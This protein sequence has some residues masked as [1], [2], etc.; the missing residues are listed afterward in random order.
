MVLFA[1]R[2]APPSIEENLGRHLDDDRANN[3]IC[4]LAW[5]SVQDNADD[6][7]RNGLIKRG[8]DVNHSRLTK[9]QVLYI[10]R[11]GKIDPEGRTG[12][13]PVLAKRFGVTDVAI[14][15]VLKRKTWLHV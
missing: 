9:E 15:A 13:A 3:T 4:N 7:V 5:G 8:S 12:N 1:F 11:V 6:A 10:R 14:R 2:G